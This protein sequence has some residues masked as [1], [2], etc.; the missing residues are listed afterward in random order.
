MTDPISES[1]SKAEDSL[2]DLESQ[3]K[4]LTHD[5]LAEKAVDIATRQILTSFDFKRPRITRIQKYWDLYDG[6]TPKKLRQLFNVPIPVFS[7]MVDT[8]NAQYDTPVQLKFKEGDASDYFKVMKLNGAFQKEVMDSAENSKWDEKLTLARSHAIV[9]GRPILEYSVTSDPEYSSDLSVV[10]LKDFNFQPRGGGKLENHLFAGTE[11]VEK[12]KSDL[13]KGAKSGYFNLKQVRDLITKCDSREYL[14]NDDRIWGERLSRFKAL[15]LDPDNNSYVGESVYKIA[16]HVLNI[17]GQ[18]YYLCFHP[19]SKTW[20]RFEKWEENNG[21]YPWVSYATHP[22]NENFL[23]KSFADDLYPAAD[24]IVAMFNQELTNREK[25][26]YGARAYDKDM[27]PDVRKLDESMHRPDALVPA[28]T[29]NGTRLIQNGI[30]EFKVGELA[31]TV[32]LIDWISGTLGRNTGATDLASGSVQEVSK[33]A[34]VTFAEQKSVSKRIAWS[35]KPFQG[36]MADL[37]KRFVFGLKDHMPSKM[38]IRLMG[39]G[40]WDWDEITRIDLDTK[41]DVDVHII[42]TDQEVQNSEMKAK[43]RTEALTLVLNSPNINAKKRDEEIL[44]SVGDYSDEEVAEFLDVKTYSDR[45]SVARA[46]VSIE[47]ILRG[48]EPELWYGATVAFMQKIVDFANDKRSTLKDKFQMLIDYANAHAEI[49]RE[50]IERKVSEQNAIMGQQGVVPQGTPAV[51]QPAPSTAANEG[52]SGG[53]SRAMSI[54]EA[55]V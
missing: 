47:M 5:Q 22:N 52:M 42:S 46:S 53:M 24:S 13:V 10:S 25:R 50:N 17:D 39:E 18:R 26:N 9:E 27:F 55:A 3:Y 15:G 2:L 41:K 1:E 7:G 36:M 20:L 37:G 6:K 21:L 30:Y 23:S 32:N 45:K 19:W 35:S 44:K 40:G 11:D 16:N 49:V 4:N 33:K 29:K 28:D 48:E 51:E 34:S 12:T 38:A 8:L 43:R 31:G 54:A 14:P